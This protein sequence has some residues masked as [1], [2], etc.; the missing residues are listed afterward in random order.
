MAV[1]ILLQE[2]KTIFPVV[3]TEHELN[4]LEDNEERKALILTK[5]EQLSNKYHK[6]DFKLIEK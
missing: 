4:A 3:I 5:F 1:D 6:V 2:K